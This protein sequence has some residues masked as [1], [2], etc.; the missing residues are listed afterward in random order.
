MEGCE[1]LAC[2]ATP[3]FFD[4]I[5]FRAVRTSFQDSLKKFHRAVFFLNCHEVKIPI[6]AHVKL[7]KLIS[8][9]ESKLHAIFSTDFIFLHQGQL[10]KKL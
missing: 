10:E 5:M 8:R 6:R 7:Q 2:L 9:A 4:A 3:R 1:N